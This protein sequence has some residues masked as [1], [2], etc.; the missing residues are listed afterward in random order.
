LVPRL[1]VV[2]RFLLLPEPLS[3]GLEDPAPG[4]LVSSTL[5][6]SSLGAKAAEMGFCLKREDATTYACFLD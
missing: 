3:G 2:D 1:A 6:I 4:A 5:S